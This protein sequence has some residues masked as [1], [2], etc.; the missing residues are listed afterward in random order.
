MR[1]N[2]PEFAILEWDFH[3]LPIKFNKI[4]LLDN[5]YA[6]IFKY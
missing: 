3:I 2:L 6:D 5:I 4:G 1:G